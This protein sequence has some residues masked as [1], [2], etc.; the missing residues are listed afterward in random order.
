MGAHPDLI[1]P[2]YSIKAMILISTRFYSY[3]KLNWHYFLFDFCYFANLVLLLNLYFYP[4]SALLFVLIFGMANGP[5][6]W[7]VPMWKNSMVFH[8]LDKVTS[9][10]IHIGPSIVTY[11]I[12]WHPK[13]FPNH[14][15]CP[16]GNC[17]IPFY[18]LAILPII[19]YTIWQVMYYIKVNVLSSHKDRMTSA[20][21]LLEGE[22]DGMVAKWSRG[23]PFGK[24]I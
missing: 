12:R 6:C 23:W 14:S 20:R 3:K 18:Y 17:D 24:K 4:Q 2:F 11:C 21:W 10:F 15:V 13:L 7:A 5:L 1:A 22:K 8:S 16:D 19:P 9:V